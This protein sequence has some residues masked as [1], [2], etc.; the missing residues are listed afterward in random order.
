[1]KIF[2]DIDDTICYYENNNIKKN[3]EYDKAIP[4]NER[5]NKINKLYDEQHEI[6][7]W[8][9]R[10][11]VTQ[12]LW[13]NETYNQLIKWGCKFHELKMGKPAYD[14]FIDDKNINSEDYFKN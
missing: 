9:A 3:M 14:L 10:G 4:Y 12:K 8:T 11:T 7:Y 1:M 2:V 13:F 5:I 6:I